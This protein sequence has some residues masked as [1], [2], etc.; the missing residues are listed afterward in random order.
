MT[1]TPNLALRSWVRAVGDHT[2]PD[3]VH[4]WTGTDQERTQVAT[5]MAKSL[6]AE[7]AEVDIERAPVIVSTHRRVDAGPTN[8]WMSRDDAQTACRRRC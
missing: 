5:A 4:W 8:I 7:P 2:Q 6:R 3:A 1:K